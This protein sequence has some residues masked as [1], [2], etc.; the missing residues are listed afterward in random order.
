[1]STS[2]VLRLLPSKHHILMAVESGSR[3]WGFPS[4]DSDYDVRFIYMHKDLRRYLSIFHV[5]G[6]I[7]QTHGDYDLSGWEVT[8]ALQL[9]SKS[10]PS[11][12]EW[13]QSP[14][15]YTEE[16]WFVDELA[17]IMN[18]SVD[19]RSIGYHYASMLRHQKQSYWREGSPVP[20]KK[21]LY[22]LRPILCL[23][24]MRDTEAF[25]PVDFTALLNYVRENLALSTDVERDIAHLLLIKS[26]SSEMGS[27]RYEVLDYLLTTWLVR[28]VDLAASLPSRNVDIDALNR[29]YRKVLVHYGSI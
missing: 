7:E 18:R 25:P 29:L 22:A 24:Y 19:L 10:N 16:S 17:G 21:Y 14:L 4:P 26:R 9:A 8:K 20:F 15:V 1:V 13:L 6:T 12:M 3:M 2:E 23:M 27:G 5:G 11:L 28:S